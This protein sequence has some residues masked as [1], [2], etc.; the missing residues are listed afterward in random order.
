MKAIVALVVLIFGSCGACCN[1][2]EPQSDAG[3]PLCEQLC[4]GQYSCDG[5]G[6]CTCEGPFV[7]H[8]QCEP[9]DA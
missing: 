6:K 7:P 2:P 1:E 5:E 4:P 8:V 3:L 9:P